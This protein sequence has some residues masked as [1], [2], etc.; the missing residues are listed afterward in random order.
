MNTQKEIKSKQRKQR[1]DQKQDRKIKQR[2]RIR[3]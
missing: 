2:H 3:R 1:N